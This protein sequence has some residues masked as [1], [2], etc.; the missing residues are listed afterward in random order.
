MTARRTNADVAD[1]FA[2]GFDDRFARHGILEVAYLRAVE[3]DGLPAYAV[4]AANGTCLW[5]DT[6]R[7]SA[8]ATLQEHGMELV[9][10]H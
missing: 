4:Y 5:L 6:D 1:G 8:G 3:I 10:V 7:A 2:A 9:S